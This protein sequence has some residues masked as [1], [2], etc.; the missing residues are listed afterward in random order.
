MELTMNNLLAVSSV[1][2]LICFI[3]TVFLFIGAI[4]RVLLYI[5][6]KPTG[7]LT[8]FWPN[9]SISLGIFGTFLGIFLGLK[10]FN[11]ADIQK[12]I[13]P[14]L[15]GLKTA[16][17]TSLFGMAVSIGLRFW[18]S[19]FDTAAI[20]QESVAS[21]DPNVLLR[22]IDT[23]IIGLSN[24]VASIETTILNLFRADEEFSLV[25]QLKIIRT[26]MNDLK[27]E[28][29][30]T[31]EDFGKKVAELGTEAMI[32]ALRQV[33]EQFNARLNDLVG[34]EFAQLKE[35]MLKLVDWQENYRQAVDTMQEQLTDHLSQ[36]QR[37]TEFLERA[38]TSIN[39]A[40]GHLDSIDGS[41][42][43]I[44]VSAEDIQ[45]HIEQLKLQNQQLSQFIDSIR[46]LGEE[47]KTVLP[48]I[49]ENINSSTSQLI[50][51]AQEA[52][53]QINTAGRSLN[54]T[55]E[56]IAN[57]MRELIRQH[58]EQVNTTSDE[59]QKNLESVLSTSLTSLAGQLA[60]LS[61]KFAEDY[62][63]LTDRLRE[64]VSIAETVTNE[65]A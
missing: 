65:R 9:A 20:K 18:Y 52:G 16:F 26:D 50:K 36:V 12:S 54:Q 41:L 56:E 4:V 42:S 22:K 34:A 55:V 60:A 44:S 1:T 2:L 43:A 29:T 19:V 25:S 35:A 46:S 38:T 32:E 40:S 21:D 15:E 33:I 28:I 47:A 24:A 7:P 58:V 57:Q 62:T 31:L 6:R 61:N 23:S 17:I 5:R 53:E 27:R 64:V 45:R 13:P 30:K 49:T 48:T 39:Q 59:I 3:I 63:P 10:A 14:L 11:T 8:A 37:S 51:A